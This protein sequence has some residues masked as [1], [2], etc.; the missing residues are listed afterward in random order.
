MVVSREKFN[1]TFGNYKK[2]PLMSI[3]GQIPN[4]QLSLKIPGQDKTIGELLRDQE[5]AL[6]DFYSSID[7]EIELQK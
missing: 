1:K 6:I 2:N 4:E 3:K 5:K 7:N